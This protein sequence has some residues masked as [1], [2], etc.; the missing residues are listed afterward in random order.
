VYCRNCTTRGPRGRIFA[1]LLLL[2]LKMTEIGESMSLRNALRWGACHG[3]DIE[4]NLML[5]A[6]SF[7][8]V[9]GMVSLH[10]A[11]LGN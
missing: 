6:G 5:D 9:N 11:F 7:L 3:V 2:V 4:G 8:E 10:K 1:Y